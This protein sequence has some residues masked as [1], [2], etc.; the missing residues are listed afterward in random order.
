MEILESVAWVALGFV[1]TIAA[2][3]A[4]WRISRHKL[5]PIEVGISR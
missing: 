2:M 4:A 5:A 3:E 1:P